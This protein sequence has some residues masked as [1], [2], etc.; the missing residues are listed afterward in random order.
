M[1]HRTLFLTVQVMI[2][3]SGRKCKGFWASFFAKLRLLRGVGEALGG[4]QEV[5]GGLGIG[6]GGGFCRGQQSCGPQDDGA[7]QGFGQRKG[8]SQP[9]G[10]GGGAADR[11]KEAEDG[12]GGG[13]EVPDADLEQ[14]HGKKGGGDGGQEGIAHGGGGE[15][16]D[17]LAGEGVIGEDSQ[18][19][20]HGGI[21]SDKEG[22]QVP[23]GG[24]IHGHHIPGIG[25]AGGEGQ[26]HAQE[27]AAFAAALQEEEDACGGQGEGEELGTA[28]ALLEG[29]TADEGDEDGV[30]KMQGGGGTYADIAI[31]D[32][33]HE[34]CSAPA[35][36]AYQQEGY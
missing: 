1:G 33:E 32:V 26:G 3:C 35:Q 27:A 29:G 15:G 24:F 8:L 23:D 19:H 10:A 14:H 20:S 16:E 22:V 25:N 5:Q 2:P 31:G 9:E 18:V 6:G 21:K 12:G 17:D 7:A 30:H 11:L 13:A 4:H 34:G 36:E 28:Q